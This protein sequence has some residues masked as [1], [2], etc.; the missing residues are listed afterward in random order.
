MLLKSP[1]MIA[2]CI[3]IL[4]TLIG[5]Q[6]WFP[7]SAFVRGLNKYSGLIMI[8]VIIVTVVVTNRMIQPPHQL[9]TVDLPAGVLVLGYGIAGG[10]GVSR[11]SPNKSRNTIVQSSAALVVNYGK[12][13]QASKVDKIC[14]F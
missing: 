7:A 8:I 11:T 1:L 12:R 13:K 14:R 3:V 6:L 10:I 2:I 5:V 9:V 4:V